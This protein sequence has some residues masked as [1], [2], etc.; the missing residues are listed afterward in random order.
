MNSD[1][2]MCKLRDELSIIARK[3]RIKGYRSLKKN[4]LVS[5]ILKCDEQLVH[6][7]LSVTW[8]DRYH[9]HIYGAA[10]IVALVLSIVFFVVP[11][12]NTTDD[13]PHMAVA[14]TT[15]QDNLI[16][17]NVRTIVDQPTVI[18]QF[19]N[20]GIMSVYWEITISNNGTMDL[21]VIDYN[22]AQVDINSGPISYS[23]MQQ[24]IYTLKEGQLVP[25]QFPITVETGHSKA[26]FLRVGIVMAENAYKLVKTK[27]K[28]EGQANVKSLIDF[29][30]LE[31][32][33]FYGNVIT[34]QEPGVFMYPEID[35]IVE[36]M[37]GISFESGRGDK[38]TEIISWYKYGLFRDHLI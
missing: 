10:T 37:F 32:T 26:L 3:L 34:K 36:Q 22:I 29:L 4:D 14:T 12:M 28:V 33:D 9:N 6:Q 19:L 8:W 18:Y 13:T 11:L 7:Y 15:V 5:A 27:F 31:G 38:T 30:R 20:T 17:S 21:S 1:L 2:L 16:V 24:G 25:V 23:N 35:Q